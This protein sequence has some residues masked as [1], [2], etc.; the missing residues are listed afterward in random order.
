[1]VTAICLL[2]PHLQAA[3]V[4]KKPGPEHKKMEMTTGKWKSEGVNFESPFGPAGKMTGTGEARMILGGF[5]LEIR[6]HSIGSEGTKDS[7]EIIAFDSVKSHYQDTY[8]ASDGSFTPVWKGECAIGTIQGDT[9]NW[10]W[11]DEKGGKKYQCREIA[12]VAADRKS[13]SIV[14]SYSEDGQVWKK[15]YE[16]KFKKVGNVRNN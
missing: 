11:N 15:L 1:M 14:G 7:V 10:S 9:W 4:A 16:A 12:T 13:F 2:A 8:F 3:D 5:F 6:Y